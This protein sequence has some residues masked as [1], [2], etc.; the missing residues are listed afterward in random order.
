MVAR[1][2]KNLPFQDTR[3]VLIDE[4]LIIAFQGFNIGFTFTFRIQI[5]CAINIKI[6]KRKSQNT[7]FKSL[8]MRD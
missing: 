2:S 1:E 8:V 7:D 6:K 3:D 4:R 5:K